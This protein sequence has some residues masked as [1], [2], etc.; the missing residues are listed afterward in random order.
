[1]PVSTLT[2]GVNTYVTR[3][4]ADTYLGDTYGQAALWA[5]QSNDQKDQALLTAFKLLERQVWQGTAVGA[6]SFPRT[7]LYDCAGLAVSSASVPDEVEQAQIELAFA[8]TQDPTLATKTTTDDN[9]KSLKAGSAAIEFFNRDGSPSQ[10]IGRFPAN[11]MELIRC[12]LA[13]YAGGMSGAETFGNECPETFDT[14]GYDRN[15]PF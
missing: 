1:M 15:N 5:A 10:V 6:I 3:A 4:E 9:T 14:D 11:V 13:S 8:I 7:D 12:F 2:V